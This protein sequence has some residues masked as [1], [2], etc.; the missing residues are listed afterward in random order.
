VVATVCCRSAHSATKVR[1]SA[2]ARRTKKEQA[3][4]ERAE[5][6]GGLRTGAALHT[7]GWLVE[8]AGLKLVTRVTSVSP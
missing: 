1:T 5:V 4:P 8:V 7:P 6:L 3:H 2:L